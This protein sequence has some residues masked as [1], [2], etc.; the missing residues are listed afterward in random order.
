MKHKSIIFAALL[1]I[2]LSCVGE[3][4]AAEEAIVGC[5]RIVS[6]SSRGGRRVS[7]MS[8]TKNADGSYAIA[9]GVGQSSEGISDVKVED[10]TLTFTRTM[11]RRDRE[12]KTS[13]QAALK[14]GKLTG[15]MTTERGE[16]P[17]TG[18]RIVP[19]PDAVGNWQITMQRGDRQIVSQLTI[20]QN[21]K[22]Q[23]EGKWTSQRGESKISNVKLE[24][25]KLTFDRV[26]TYNEREM[27]S[28]FA[29]QVKGNELTGTITSERGEREVTAKRQGTEIIGKWELTTQSERGER[30]SV[31]LVEKD[32]STVLGTGYADTPVTDLKLEGDKVTFSITMG[33]RDRQFKTQYNLTLAAGALQGEAVSDR[34]TNKVTGKKL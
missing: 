20:S 28:S 6:E 34:G 14:E 25:G 18:T 4:F 19:L 15:K 8:V 16:T 29:G 22:G 33:F 2:L 17:F 26:T 27:K 32:L 23:L 9:L 7:R 24:D 11:T 1:V 30:K 5:W 12:M 3:I 21:D 31:L 13:Y 10:N